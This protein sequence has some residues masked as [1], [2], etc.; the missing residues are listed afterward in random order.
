MSLLE[1]GVLIGAANLISFLLWY[2]FGPK[3]GKAAAIRSG[4]QEVTIRVEGAYHPSA[5][6]VKAGIPVRMKFDRREGTDCSNRV[7]LPDFDISRALPAFQTTAVEFTPKEPGQ[8]PFACAMNMYRGTLL[9][10]PN[11]QAHDDQPVD[12]T[13]ASG[14]AAPGQVRPE[15]APHPSPDERPSQAHF[16]I[17]GMRSITTTTAVEDLLER[18]PGV[19]R[20]QVNA[21]T[22]RATVDY[23]PGLTSPDRLADAIRR[24]GYE[25]EPVSPEVQ[26]S[27]RGTISRESEISDISRRFW[28][29][30]VLTLPVFVGAMGHLLFPMPAGTLG[31]LLRFLEHPYVQLALTT[32]V[33]FYSGWGFFRGTWFTLKN[34]TADMNTL[35][36][37]G[38]GAAYLYSLAATFL[39]GWLQ[40]RGV[41]AGLYYETAAVIV[42]LILLGRLLE[43]RAKAGTSAAI[44]KLLSL[45]AKTARVRRSGREEDI[46]VEEVRAGDHVI[47][48]PGEKVPVDGTI[49][50]GE[51]TLDESMVTGESIPVTKGPGDPVIGATINRAGGFVFE[52][53]K[54]GTDT[55]LAQIVRLVQ[56]AQ[57]SKAPIQRLADVVSGY[58]VPA[59][60]VIAVLTFAIWFAFG[61]EPAF[62]LA[63]LN[64]VAILLIA[65]PCALGLATPT[66]I[67]VATGKGAENGILIK[68]AEA[69]EVTGRLTAVILDK[70]GTLTQGQPAV[71]EVAAGKEAAEEEVLRLVASTQR[72]SDHPLAQA[73]VRAAEE[74]GL[75]LPQATEFRYFTGM[76]TRAVVEGA[77]LL[78]G[79]RRLM[80]E[81]KVDVS[82]FQAEAERMS[83]EGMTVNFVAQKGRLVGLIGLADVIRPTSK[84]AVEELHRLGV[85]AVM[86]TGDNW[87]VARAVARE[88]GIDTVLAEVM[89]EHKASEVAKLQ[90]QGKVVAMVGDGIN[91]APALA[92]AD[93]GIAIG[94][95]TDVAIESADVVLI[96]NDVFDVTR[97][98][99]LSRATMR[100]IKQNLF[101]AFIYNGL[102]IPVAA[103]VLYPFFGVLLSPILAAG[104]MAAS[105]ISVVLNALRLKAFR[106]PGSASPAEA[107]TVRRPRQS[108]GAPAMPRPA[109]P[110]E[111]RLLGEDGVSTDPVCGMSVP[112]GQAAAES[113]FGG[114]TYAFCS[115]GC[116]QKFDE[117]PRR[118]AG[119]PP[120]ES[121][122]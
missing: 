87:G 111:Q 22:E 43:V 83:G 30:L 99:R 68:N 100:N 2:F 74:R 45:Q 35:I 109:T 46:P 41:E 40:G 65:C 20:V 13:S 81:R 21:D 116:R 51:S 75:P 85:E 58:F 121:G 7:V 44:E 56:E 80:D 91:D 61:P 28:L 88:V 122:P 8:Y 104:A 101:F 9:V 31:Q 15:V 42:T 6:T 60:I 84:R 77:E 3:Q 69:L 72:S 47:V 39:G 93:V 79:N 107:S 11:G 98:V 76:G 71:R 10:E 89:P 36:G 82:A 86:I 53:T 12:G 23:V 118:Y 117:D 52:A 94:A 95:G 103:G 105:S 63:L 24:A 108:E 64:T 55:M 114:R 32:P 37:I 26:Q 17:R 73:I 33:L 119:G 102:G 96:R 112:A 110:G 50:E 48:R 106:L 57:G 14:V 120:V 1:V 78:V 113:E 92:Q 38:T 16:L 97:T 19:E 54:V 62:V 90:R 66:S 115:P 70:T 59:V 18:Q 67:M 49:V 4:V 5:V 27:D 25:A 29:A 34:R